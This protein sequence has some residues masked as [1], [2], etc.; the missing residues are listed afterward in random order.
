M[1][2]FWLDEREIFGMRRCDEVMRKDK[3][4]EVSR[5]FIEEGEV[6]RID[7]CQR[8]R[9]LANPHGHMEFPSLGT[10]ARIA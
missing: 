7:V 6:V 2:T 5:G 10:R 4:R 8:Q 9:P 3:R 1:L